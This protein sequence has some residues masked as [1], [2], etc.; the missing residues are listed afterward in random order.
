MDRS[1]AVNGLNPYTTVGG[2][3]FSYDANG[4]LTSDGVNSY[5]YDVENRLIAGPNEA[6][7]VWDPLGTLFESYSSSRAPTLRLRRRP[8][9]GGV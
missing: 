6:T 9:D 4:N 3:G 8:A 5:T 7:L 1:Y 2:T